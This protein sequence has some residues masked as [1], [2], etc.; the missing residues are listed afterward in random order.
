MAADTVSIDGRH[1][2][3]VLEAKVLARLLCA[4]S[5]ERLA[6]AARAR[7]LV[8]GFLVAAST[9]SIRG[10]VER[11]RVSRERDARVALDTIDAFEDVRAVLE[12]M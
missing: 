4:P 2:T 5:N 8:M 12:G 1:V 11:T 3:A 10:K 9:V 7:S 6:V